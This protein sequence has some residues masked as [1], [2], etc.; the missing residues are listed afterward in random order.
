M[1]ELAKVKVCGGSPVKAK[2]VMH[3][4]DIISVTIIN[5]GYVCS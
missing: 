4:L 3:E 2:P 5:G 1:A